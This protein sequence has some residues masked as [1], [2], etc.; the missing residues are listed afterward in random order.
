VRREAREETGLHVQPQALG[1]VYKNM[2][3]SAVVLTF[4]CR[5][6]SGSLT[7]NDEASESAG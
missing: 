2:T 6:V 4:R 5:V 1:A 7:A 3:T